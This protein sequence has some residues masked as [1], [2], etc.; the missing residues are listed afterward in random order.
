MKGRKEVELEC[1]YCGMKLRIYNLPMNVKFIDECRVKCLVCN[2]G[3]VMIW[4]GVKK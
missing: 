3:S 1:F 4:E 2:N